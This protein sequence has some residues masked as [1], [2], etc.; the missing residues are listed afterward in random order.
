MW[1]KQVAS[2]LMEVA[3]QA[4]DTKTETKKCPYTN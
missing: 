1:M 2:G 3:L 4:A